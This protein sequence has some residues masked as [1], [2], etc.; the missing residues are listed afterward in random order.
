LFGD[1]LEKAY[2]RSDIF[3]LPTSYESFGRVYIEAMAK[4]LPIVT[5]DVAAVRNVVIG[6]RNGLLSET[7]A[8]SFS[9]ALREMITNTDLYRRVS[10][11]NLED[12]RAYNWHRFVDRMVDIYSEIARL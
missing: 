10:I 11:Q 9:N 2:E 8:D 7:N 4:A 3:V 12:V 6:N 5:T 1:D